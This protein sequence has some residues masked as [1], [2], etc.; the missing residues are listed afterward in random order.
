[1]S[2]PLMA[3][4]GAITGL[5]AAFLVAAT[6]GQAVLAAT[7]GRILRQSTGVPDGRRLDRL[8][9]RLAGSAVAAAVVAAATRW[10]VAGLG[11][12]LAVWTLPAV[13]RGRRSHGH[14]LART[15]AIATW[16]EQLRD[17]LAAAS[18]LEQAV[19]ATAAVAPMALAQPVGL[20]AGRASYEPLP[21]ALRQFADDVD[22]PLADFVVAALVIAAE[23]E[24]RDVGPLLGELAACARDDAR[25]RTRVWVS[26]A[27]SRSAAQ[28]ITA[29]IA[30]FVVGLLLFNRTYL[31]PYDSADGQAVL[32]IVMTSFAAALAA[33]T[34][35]GRVTVPERFIGRREEVS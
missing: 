3:V 27:R 2:V 20:L 8:I 19:A 5:G 24:A 34:R 32:A 31:E 12:A 28:I 17:T 13:A 15:E 11:A 33:M 29:V 10:P 26:R 14:E 9:A 30:V 35:I 7:T 18:G 1:M 23:R 22:H 25:M 4:L 21:G 16:T 6:T